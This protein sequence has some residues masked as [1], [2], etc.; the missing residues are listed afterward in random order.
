VCCC[1]CCT[2]EF[3]FPPLVLFCWKTHIDKSVVFLGILV[4]RCDFIRRVSGY[5]LVSFPLVS[6]MELVTDMF[7]FCFL[8]SSPE[9]ERVI[10]DLFMVLA[11]F[12]C[13]TIPLLLRSV[14]VLFFRVV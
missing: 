4:A 1:C 10:L 6:L 9:S 13:A 8:S 12:A 2:G 3:F 7:S 5:F 14:G 11:W